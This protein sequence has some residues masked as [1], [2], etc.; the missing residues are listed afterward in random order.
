V[1]RQLDVLAAEPRALAS[2]LHWQDAWG[3][4]PTALLERL[5]DAPA[6]P[7][8]VI[9]TEGAPPLR[10]VSFQGTPVRV[11]ELGRVRSFPGLGANPLV[12]TSTA[13]LDRATRAAGLL[14]PL[15][16]ANWYVWA[17]G[18]PDVVAP[19]LQRAG[20]DGYYMTTVDTF[21]ESPEVLLATRT[22][23]YLRTIALAAGALVLVGLLLYLQ[24]RQRSQAIA[25]ALG[26]RMGLSRAA[27]SLSLCLEVA[28]ILLFAGVVGALVATAAARP[29]VERIDPLPDR[30]PAP[31]FVVPTTALLV[32]AAVAVVVAVA[33]GLLASRL[34]RRADVSE[35]LR[36]A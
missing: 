11:T 10:S 25:S 16:A 9:A 6:L 12:V 7:L 28:G 33:S 24:A 4:D 23:G 32:A 26:R 14:D 8:P 30:P 31:V 27:E 21:R 1:G 13:A 19:A 29:V 35:A 18:P 20:I 17:K 15:D 3:P 2:V 36:V 34:A 22:Y 5:A